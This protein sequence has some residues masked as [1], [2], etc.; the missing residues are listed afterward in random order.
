MR[1]HSLLLVFTSALAL[2]CVALEP[3]GGGGGGTSQPRSNPTTSASAATPAQAA[4][5]QRVMVPLLKA[6]DQPVPVDQVSVG[7]MKDPQINAANAGGGRFFVTTGLL[8]R[9]ND[10]QLRGVLAHE[11]AH[12]D[13]D[14]VAKAQVL[15]AGLG[16]GAVLIDQVF[17]GTGQIA[18]IAGELVQRK[19]SRSEEF[20][21]DRHGVEL[22]Q[23]AGYRK[24]LMIEALTWL[25]QVSGDSGGGFFSTH[26]GTV[27]RIAALRGDR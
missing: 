21:A 7:I 2:G 23:R 18:P 9:A 14:H 15:A 3:A 6:M 17:P 27:E 11:I 10:D 8:E 20:A 13:L 12:E 24:D 16:L 19:Y 5:L 26:P 1:R 22:L 4:R 25:T